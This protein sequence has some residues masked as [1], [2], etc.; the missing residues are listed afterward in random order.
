[1]SGLRSD[2]D[3]NVC[4]S[5]EC[6]RKQ[7]SLPAPLRAWCDLRLLYARHY[8]RRPQGLAG[9][10][11]DLGIAFQ[12]R[13]HSGLCDARNTA[14]LAARMARD[15]CRI[16]VTRTCRPAAGA[17]AAGAGPDVHQRLR[18]NLS[19]AAHKSSVKTG[20]LCH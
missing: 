1:M 3:I 17:G 7:L 4:L 6:R 11:R 15:G 20:D 16:G 12:G 13:E 10:L 5:L 18:A 8:R 2:W 19:L 9:A 14:M